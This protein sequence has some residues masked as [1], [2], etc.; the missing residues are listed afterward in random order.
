MK[1]WAANGAEF[2][3]L[4]GAQFGAFVDS[5]IKRWADVVKTSGAK[6]D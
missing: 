4:T 2:P 3:D 6:L 5:E 1:V